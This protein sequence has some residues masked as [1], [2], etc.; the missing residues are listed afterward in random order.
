MRAKC[1]ECDQELTAI[2]QETYYTPLNI[3]PVGEMFEWDTWY[4]EC[5]ESEMI[6]AW[7]ES[8]GKEWNE[9]QV[10]DLWVWI[11]EGKEIAR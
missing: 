7:C 10:E 5:V 9:D 2:V 4:G 1:P 8:C 6:E 3:S 11:F